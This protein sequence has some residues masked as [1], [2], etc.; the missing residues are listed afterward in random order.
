[1]IDFDNVV[2]AEGGAGVEV[3]GGVYVVRVTAAVRD[4]KKATSYTGKDGKVVEVPAKPMLS[5]AF[6]IAEGPYAG[7]FS[8]D[9]Y[10]RNIWKHSIELFESDDADKSRTKAR[11]EK[12]ADSNSTPA[13][14]F[15]AFWAYNAN[16]DLFVGKLVG[17]VLRRVLKDGKE[18]GRGGR[19]TNESYD[20]VRVLTVAE[21]LSGRFSAPADKDLRG[22]AKAPVRAAAP[23]PAVEDE[24]IPF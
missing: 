21:A 2:A 1:M 17:V 12:V 24:D 9:H 15:D 14:R 4:V 7:A 16:P 18:D 6:D 13:Q 22:A 23:E 5:L 3:P 8:S 11:L 19:Y 10:Q 20:V